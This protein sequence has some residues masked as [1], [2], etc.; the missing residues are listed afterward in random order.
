MAN[1]Q[2]NIYLFD[3]LRKHAYRSVHKF[4]DKPEEWESYMYA[5]ANVINAD[6]GYK[7]PNKVVKAVARSVMGYTYPN[8]PYDKDCV[9]RF[10]EKQVRAAKRSAEVRRQAAEVKK[11]RARFLKAEGYSIAAIVEELKVGK[12]SVYAWLKDR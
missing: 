4:R 2:E 8:S 11:V 3:N 6:V 1:S 5:C 10:K 7:L 12:S 9:S